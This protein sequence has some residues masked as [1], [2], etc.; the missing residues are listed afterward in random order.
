MK[1]LHFIDKLQNQEITEGTVSQFLPTIIEKLA[2]FSREELIGKIVAAEFEL[3][4]EYYKDAP[5]INI[6]RQTRERGEKGEPRARGNFSRLFINLGKTD[7]LNAVDI[8]SLV[9]SNT[10]GMQVRIGQIEILKNFSFFEVDSAFEQEVIKALDKQ[11]IN[12]YKLIVEPA[13]AKT[14][15][16]SGERKF[17]RDRSFGDRP[18][19]TDR[20]SDRGGYPRGKER[21]RRPRR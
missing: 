8:I 9:N 10:R 6:Y 19:R 13:T 16:G 20:G 15:G 5:D 2:G 3:F 12:G 11:V 7:R 18:R 21:E 1:L 14:G 4:N 17:G